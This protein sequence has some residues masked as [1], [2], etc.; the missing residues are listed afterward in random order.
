MPF[1]VEVLEL[2]CLRLASLKEEGL[3]SSRC[4]EV[5]ERRRQAVLGGRSRRRWREM[6][7]RW[8]VVVVVVVVAGGVCCVKRVSC[9]CVVRRVMVPAPPRLLEAG[10]YTE[11]KY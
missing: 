2:A 5:G 9:V 4:L 11:G 8:D 10:Q 3:N 7:W 1:R 6:G